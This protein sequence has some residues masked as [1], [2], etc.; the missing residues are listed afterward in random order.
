[1]G[2]R[3]KKKVS[4]FCSEMAVVQIWPLWGAFNKCMDRC[5]IGEKNTEVR[6]QTWRD[7]EG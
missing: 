5:T 4:A 1:M 2:L 7:K 3:Q 6:L